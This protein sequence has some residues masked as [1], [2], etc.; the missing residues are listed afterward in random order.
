MPPVVLTEEQ[1]AAFSNLIDAYHR[2][3]RELLPLGEP[4]TIT[5][6]PHGIVSLTD[7]SGFQLAYGI[8][9]LDGALSSFEPVFASRSEDSTVK[10]VN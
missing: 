10:T 1:Q 3:G 4:I 6:G 9:A 7:A 5:L 8:I 2:L